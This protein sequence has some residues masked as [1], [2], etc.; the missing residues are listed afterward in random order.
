MS[1]ITTTLTIL[2]VI[3]FYFL[4]T[5]GTNSIVYS[6]VKCNPKDKTCESIALKFSI[7]GWILFV[8]TLLLIYLSFTLTR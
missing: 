2:K 3:L 6:Y 7:I 5:A 8:V 4:V 1:Y